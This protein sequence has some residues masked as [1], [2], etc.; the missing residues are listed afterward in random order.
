[1]TG[2]GGT[3]VAPSSSRPALRLARRRLVQRSLSLAEEL[4]RSTACHGCASQPQARPRLRR[5]SSGAA[6]APATGISPTGS[7][8]HRCPKRQQVDYGNARSATSAT[9]LTSV[10][11]SSGHDWRTLE[12]ASWRTCKASCGVSQG[13]VVARRNY[14]GPKCRK[15][16]RSSRL[17]SGGPSQNSKQPTRTN[18]SNR[19]IIFARRFANVMRSTSVTRTRCSC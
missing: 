13:S 11:A 17:K 1:M 19:S 9:S 3:R 14:D 16:A 18:C 5:I 8:E 6:C 12:G 7:A 2:G 15:A 4:G 10:S